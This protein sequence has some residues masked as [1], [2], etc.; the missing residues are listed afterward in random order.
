MDAV[1][2]DHVLRDARHHV[3]VLRG[4]AEIFIGAVGTVEHIQESPESAEQAPSVSTAE[5]SRDREHRLATPPREVERRPLVGHAPCETH[6]VAKSV[7]RARIL[8]HPAPTDRVTEGV[9]VQRNEDPG[10]GQFVMPNHDTYAVPRLDQF[11][12]ALLVYHSVRPCSLI[13]GQGQFWRSSPDSTSVSPARS[14][15]QPR[16]RRPTSRS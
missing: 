3:H 6:S 7:L 16:G 15:Y 8:L 12:E 9:V 4:R 13:S 5:R 10:A 1:N 2:G 14:G 11:E